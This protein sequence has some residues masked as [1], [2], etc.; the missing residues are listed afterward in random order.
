MTQTTPAPQDPV[1]DKE[2][3]DMS[4][5]SNTAT[6]NRSPSQPETSIT[7]RPK[8]DPSKAPESGDKPDAEGAD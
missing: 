2:A 7:E 1:R 4:E 6:P 5:A 8:D 3:R